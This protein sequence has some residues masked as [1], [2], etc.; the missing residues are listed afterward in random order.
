MN[1]V[2]IIILIVSII[3]LILSIKTINKYEISMYGAITF[4]ALILFVINVFVN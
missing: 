2:L 3:G 1:T 4:W